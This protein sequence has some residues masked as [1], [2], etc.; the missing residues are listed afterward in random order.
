MGTLE[1]SKTTLNKEGIMDVHIRGHRTVTQPRWRD[2]IYE[3]L[4]KL[5][6]FQDQLIKINVILTSSH[7]HLK[8]NELCRINVKV[9]K[10]TIAI[11]K[12]AETMMEAIDHS[13]KILEQQV[14]GLW[15]KEKSK[16]RHSKEAR[17]LKRGGLI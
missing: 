8:G 11:R 2:H 5:D 17:I 6:R 14:H 16:K 3:R 15:K 9:P 13:F 1:H 4:S 7:H 10:K 12:R